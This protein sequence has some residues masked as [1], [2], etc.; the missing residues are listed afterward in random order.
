MAQLAAALLARAARPFDG[1]EPEPV[2]DLDAADDAVDA[3]WADIER[4]VVTTIARRQPVAVDLRWLVAALQTGLHLERIADGAVE[5]GHVLADPTQRIDGTV[6]AH[7]AS[8]AR[9]AVTMANHAVSALLDLDADGALRV[10]T[11]DDELDELHRRTFEQFAASRPGGLDGAMLVHVDR[12]SRTLER[13]GD[14]AVDIAELAL[15]LAT[16]ELREL[17]HC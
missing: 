11:L 15:F 12:A 17:D 1:G 13:A 7:L 5:L 8:M 4:D 9:L 6:A 14:H 16:G 3:A 2:A 10:A